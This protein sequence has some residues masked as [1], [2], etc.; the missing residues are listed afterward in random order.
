MVWQEPIE[1]VKILTQHT[2]HLHWIL[3]CNATD[4]RS[5]VECSIEHTNAQKKWWAWSVTNIQTG[6]CCITTTTTTKHTERQI[7][8]KHLWRWRS[9]CCLCCMCDK[10]NYEYSALRMY[11]WLYDIVNFNI[12]MIS[13]LKVGIF[14]ILAQTHTKQVIGNKWTCGYIAT[15]IHNFSTCVC[16][17]HVHIHTLIVCIH[18]QLFFVLCLISKCLEVQ[19]FGSYQASKVAKA[20][21]IFS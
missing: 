8:S 14:L 4:E 16:A 15:H 9:P 20:S 3:S 11:S 13:Y 19:M 5:S 17:K 21:K 2:V 12:H 10:K 6:Y 18:T 1:E 7:K